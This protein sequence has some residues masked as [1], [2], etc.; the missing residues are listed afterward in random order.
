MSTV[1]DSLSIQIESNSA[2]AASGID[3][4]A[5][6]LGE[7]KKNA[8]VGVAVKNLNSLS[9]ALK[10][11]A[12]AA[13]DAS[14]ISALAK[15]MSELKTVGSV[16]TGVK[17]LTESLKSLNEVTNSLDD[18]TITRFAE[19]VELVAEKLSPLSEKMVTV[20]G[21]FNAIESGARAAAREVKGFGGKLD[22]S[23]INLSSFIH[24]LQN[25]VRWIQKIV[26]AFSKFISDASEWDGIS[27]RFGRGFGPQAQETYEW[28][29]KLGD[30]MGINAQQFMQYSSTYATMLKGFGVAQEDASKMA[31]G[32]M[33]LT[34]DIWAGYNDQYKSLE[35]AAE[36][37]RSAIAGEVEPVR[38]AGFTIVE[39]TLEQT[40]ANNGLKISLEK[41]NEEQKSYLRY[42]TMVDQAHAQS[43]VGAYAKEMNT[44][45][46]V[47]RTFAQQTKSLAQAFGSLFLPVLVKVMPYLQAVVSVLTDAVYW[48]AE[49]FNI[50]IQRVDFSNY[51]SSAENTAEGLRKATKA[52]KELKNA[53]IGIDEL[54]IIS[55]QSESKENASGWNTNFD[56]DSL[57]DET[58]FAG[59]QNQVAE[60]KDE[61]KDLLK[62]VTAVGVGFA[63]WKIGTGLVAGFGSATKFFDGLKK[64]GD[65]IGGA[66]ILTKIDDFV[67][68][69][70]G[71]NTGFVVGETAL[72]RFVTA[73][74]NI[75][76]KLGPVALIVF[77]VISA[78][79]V[80]YERWDDIK[81]SVADAFETLGI[82]E[83]WA[84]LKE[85]FAEL[86][87]KL[88][89]FGVM[90][91][92]AKNLGG[93]FVDFVGG[94]L[95]SVLGGVF[96][97]AV[98]GGI[99]VLEGLVTIASGVADAFNGL[100]DF[101]NGV[102]SKDFK[103]AKDGIDRIV[104]GIGGIFLGLFESVIGGLGGFV[105]G[106]IEGFGELGATLIT[107][108][109]P[110]LMNDIVK[111]FAKLPVAMITI[112]KNI[113]IGLV[114]GIISLA[115]WFVGELKYFFG[116]A[117]DFVSS[118]FSGIGGGTSVAFETPAT[119]ATGGFP[120]TGQ[121]FIAREAGPEMVGSI[122]RRT[123]V[124]NNDQIVE[125][126]RAGVHDAQAEQNSLLAE[127][128]DLLRAI[129]AKEGHV[130][131]DPRT[132]KRA[133]DRATRDA[134]VSIMMGGVMS[135]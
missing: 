120:T 117:W 66:K 93:A 131:L 113:V 6:S 49:F 46:G 124:A 29:Q 135:R 118:V 89:R 70:T 88:W 92:D 123:A 27:A 62:V 9:D 106:F 14:K 116:P 105:I 133:V 65:M 69:L 91:A 3:A 10:N 21:G 19:R 115:S 132:A 110:N 1:I 72:T 75:V 12:N 8:S 39:S 74:S 86:D 26:D 52:A 36:A 47:M 35:D 95:V 28:I 102:F 76:T 18:E 122:G 71:L 11:V 23:S 20:Q 13:P 50:D 73:A 121:M 108:T 24:I 4:L 2:G 44:A 57:W 5:K 129:L 54:N 59:I 134:G 96:V 53:T 80:L 67:L 103:L 128:N 97:G 42:L 17:K 15:A 83:R 112:G 111:C 25:G 130:Y 78:L 41:A 33:E 125:G 90:F 30:M 104:S 34:Y 48:L 126:I 31:L 64:I 40:A 85:M 63:A 37:V 61:V 87:G 98:N 101:L 84:T 81:A 7:L 56:I 77:A 68:G 114:K 58:I 119:F 38:K 99:I 16:G 94:T 43:L 22:S 79:K 109:I 60:L 32:Y 100:T 51:A 107:D 55:P 127:Q 45:E 82:S